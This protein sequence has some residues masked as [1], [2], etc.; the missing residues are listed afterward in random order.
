MALKGSTLSFVY[1]F[2]IAAASSKYQPFSSTA[3]DLGP[4]DK[5]VRLPLEVCYT[6]YGLSNDTEVPQVHALDLAQTKNVYNYFQNNFF[7][8]HE[9]DKY[10]YSFVCY[11]FAQPI[12][13]GNSLAKRKYSPKHGSTY[14]VYSNHFS[15]PFN[16]A[17]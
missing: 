14:E 5:C 7:V 3:Y 9:C 1:V 6:E 17:L 16:N 10:F 8:S 13:L 2:S 15:R 11:S 12:C 4:L